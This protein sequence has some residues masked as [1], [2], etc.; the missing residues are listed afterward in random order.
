MKKFLLVM[1]ALLFL[2]SAAFSSPAPFQ[3]GYAGVI[4][5]MPLSGRN[6]AVRPLS[7]YEPALAG[8][9]YDT[10]VVVLGSENA[11]NTCFIAAGTHGNEIAGILAGYWIAENCTV[12][13]G[14]L[15]LLPRVNASG[16]L[17]IEDKEIAQR[18]IT[19]AGRE[20]H[21]G[22][23]LT[24][25]RFEVAEDPLNFIP[26]QAPAD[27]APLAGKEARNI[28]RNYPGSPSA[29]MT[30][31]VAFAVT[32]LLLEIQPV[33]AIDLH[34]A[35]LKS[36]LAWSIITRKEFLDE[37]AMAVLDVEDQTGVSF[38]LEDSREEF[39]GYSHWE[40]GKLGIHAFLVETLNPAQPD[41]DPEI[42]QL[43]NRVSPLALRVFVHLKA[44]ENLIASRNL[45]LDDSET[46]QVTG[47]PRTIDG[48]LS[49]LHGN[50]H[51]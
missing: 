12:E 38:H 14:R 36:S 3:S 46:I 28:N 7:D 45:T 43:N 42:D 35:S 40:W 17:R 4:G 51:E 15:V 11:K 8:T 18:I 20:F 47:F 26:P 29:S 32:K 19:L 5:E 27:F 48:V 9:V 6:N 31:R 16:L 34:E 49:W 10:P 37:A 44:V 41:D 2:N 13:N 33:L 50:V 39:S 22:S 1:A 23:R 24:D 21:Y 25:W 30:S